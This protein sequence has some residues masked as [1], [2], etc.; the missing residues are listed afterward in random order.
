[1][2]LAAIIVGAVAAYLAVGWLSAR[3]V[4]RLVYA[5][6]RKTSSDFNANENGT[7]AAF[8]TLF[9]WP[10]GVPAAGVYWSVDGGVFGRWIRRGTE[11]EGRTR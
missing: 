5:T 11:Y 1:M 6:N 2:T 10:L 4:Y 3:L 7:I 9:L 8:L